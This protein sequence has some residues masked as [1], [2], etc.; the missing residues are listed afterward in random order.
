MYKLI[1][2]SNAKNAEA[3]QDWICN[4]VLPSIRK[5]GSI[6]TTS[7]TYGEALLEAGRLAIE[8]ERLLTQAKEKSA[9]N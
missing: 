2:R 6:T 7:K 9:K 1:M 3:F 8:N 5:T 4:E